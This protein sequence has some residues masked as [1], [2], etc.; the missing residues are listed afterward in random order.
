MSKIINVDFRTKEEK[1]ASF[2]AKLHEK[3]QDGK[4]WFIM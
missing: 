2:K 1:R 3:I 4:D